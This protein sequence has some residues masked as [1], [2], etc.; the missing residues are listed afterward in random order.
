M[1]E[2]EIT[3][4]KTFK[5][6]IQVTDKIVDE[7]KITCD[8]D[9]MRYSCLDRGHVSFISADF[10]KDY[11]FTYNC[12]EPETLT[13]DSTELLNILKR[14]KSNDLLRISHDES[15]LILTFVGEAT[16]TFRIRLIDAEYDNP[17]PPHIEYPVTRL[18]LS[19]KDWW[20][21]VKDLELYTDKITIKTNGDQLLVSGE[22]DKGS[23]EAELQA[24]DNNADRAYKS[25]FSLDHVK[26]LS[27]VSGSFYLSFGTDM[28]ILLESLN[29]ME[30]YS[31]G[32]LIAPRIE[33]DD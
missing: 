28:P 22:G 21:T 9:G 17:T 18:E 15:N 29:G 10:N 23:Y 32:M 6:I 8:N 3:D 25:T 31:Y 30:G 27:S 2:C 7:I 33:A 19:F 12:E 16:R 11:F 1:L 13:I 24:L 5:D 20:D 26:K 14:A 4:T